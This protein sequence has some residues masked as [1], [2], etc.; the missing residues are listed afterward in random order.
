[1]IFDFSISIPT[2]V[3]VSTLFFGGMWKVFTLARKSEEALRNSLETKEKLIDL[4]LE[5]AKD[6]PNNNSL[7]EVED[8]LTKAIGDLATEIRQLRSYIMEK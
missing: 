7:K 1:M 8:R 3:A 2:I 6:Y 4:K 5:L